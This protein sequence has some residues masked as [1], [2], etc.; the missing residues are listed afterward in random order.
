MSP[1]PFEQAVFG[2]RR[3]GIKYDLDRMHALI[4]RLDHPYRA[5]PTLHVA[6]TN[7]KGS[8][9]AFLAAMLGAAGYRVGLNTSPHLVS[10]TERFRIDGVAVPE[11]LLRD[12]IDRHTLDFEREEASFFEAT[13]A[14]AF[15]AFRE[16]EVDVAVF[17]AGLGGRL[18]AT[19]VIAPVG[20][21]ITSLGLEH[22]RILG[23]TIAAIAREKGGILK[24]GVPA[25][26]SATQPEARA[27][28]RSIASKRGLAI[29]FLDRGVDFDEAPGGLV[30]P[31]EADPIPL[32]LE[33][34]HQAENA[35][36][37]LALVERLHADGVFEIPPGARR[38]GLGNARW[39]G[40]FDRRRVG[41]RDVVFD[42]AHNPDGAH[43]LGRLLHRA[44]PGCR[45][46]L[47]LGM[48][49]DKPHAPFLD[50]ILP[51]VGPVVVTT[52]GHEQRCL[53]AHEMAT[54]VRER[55]VACEVEA[56]PAAAV[57][58]ALASGGEVPDPPVLVTGSLFT[59]GAAMEGLGLR[60]GDEPI[61]P[62]ARRR[63]LEGA[64]G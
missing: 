34:E 61:G 53:H 43:A 7:G 37:A 27:V 57:R 33:G 29:R 25:V 4:R 11:R 64:P 10:Y 1:T 21:A 56:D 45:P 32:G 54:L 38:R 24:P 46:P 20:T 12:L 2:L 19:N 40:R 6:G 35:A 23:D 59:V 42:V 47:V 22:T 18:D 16:L 5:Y 28:L 55:G 14:L 39:P 58:R 48:L 60:P 13:T 63:P 15:L 41:G 3:T 9:A 52:P 30:V 8:T 26:T 17:E 62:V 31:G 36:V 51:L 49:R 44:W 50:A